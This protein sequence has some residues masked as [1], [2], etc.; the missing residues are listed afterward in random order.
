LLPRITQL[1]FFGIFRKRKLFG[2]EVMKA[3][4]ERSNELIMPNMKTVRKIL[5]PFLN[6][7]RI[8]HI[9]PLSGGLN[10]SNIKITT[11]NDENYVLR[12][13][14]KNNKRMVI[15]REIVNLLK[16]RFPV[17]QVLYFDFTCALFNYPF[18]ILNWVQGVHLSEIIYR[19]NKKEISSAASAVGETLARIHKIKFPDSGF[20]DEKLNIID[21]VKLNANKFI[22]YIKESLVDGNVDKHLGSEVCNEILSFSQKHAHLI[23]NLGEQNS[24]VHGDFNPLNIIMKE[25]DSNISISAI[26]DWEYAFSGS[27]LIDIGNMLRYE[28]VIFTELLHPFISSYQDNGGY[29][30]DK[31]LQK[32]K[33]LD[34]I[35]LCG[36]LN[37]KECGEVRVIDIKRIIINTMKEWDIYQT[38]QAEFV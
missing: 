17:P 28:N 21:Y 29:L 16:K 35:A 25:I 4:W 14:S 24:L 5:K 7:K 22:M 36:L 20:F 32:A 38:V 2:G 1:P 10:N 31:W 11:N 26:L 13:Y 12:I 23:D 8:N 3:G 33:L 19:K 34:L 30:Q 15:E 27:P 18:L 37:K 6:E 9:Q